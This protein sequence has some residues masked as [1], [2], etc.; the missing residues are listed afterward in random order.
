R[1]DDRKSVGKVEAHLVAENRQRAGSRAVGLE[2]AFVQDAFE[3]VV[4]LPHGR[5]VDRR[6][7]LPADQMLARFSRNGTSMNTRVSRADH[8]VRLPLS[9]TIPKAARASPEA[10]LIGLSQ[11]RRRVNTLARPRPASRKGTPRP[12]E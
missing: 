6:H 11:R 4:I 10:M 9:I 2:G 5:I 1:R 12:N 3:E 8:A 7:R